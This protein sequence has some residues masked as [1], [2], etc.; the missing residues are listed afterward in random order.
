M[1]GRSEPKEKKFKPIFGCE[2]ADRFI[3]IPTLKYEQ[4][5]THT[6]S[7]LFFFIKTYLLILNILF[8][9]NLKDLVNHL[10]LGIFLQIGL[11]I[12]NPR[13]TRFMFLVGTRWKLLHPVVKPHVLPALF[14]QY[15]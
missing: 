5:V 11:F 13:L 2:K 1:M 10:L 3:Q 8:L 7:K 4:L 15:A 14:H 9:I 6:V 12:D